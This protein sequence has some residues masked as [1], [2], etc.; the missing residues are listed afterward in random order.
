MDNY[1]SNFAILFPLGAC[2]YIAMRLNDG[3]VD[4]KRGGWGRSIVYS[5]ISLITA[6]A[7]AGIMFRLG[8]ISL[9]WL[10]AFVFAMLVIATRSLSLNR[11]A[12]FRSLSM[13]TSDVARQRMADDFMKENSW[14]VHR[15]ASRF[16]QALH[17]GRPW[18]DAMQESGIAKTSS[19]VFACRSVALY[20]KDLE[21]S[22]SPLLSPMRM[23]QEVERLLGRIY[24]LPWSLIGIAVITLTM[25]IIVPTFKEMFEEFDLTLPPIMEAFIRMSDLVTRDLSPLLYPLFGFVFLAAMYVVLAWLFPKLAQYYPLRPFTQGYYQSLGIT[26]LAI[27]LRHEPDFATA[28]TIASRLMPVSFIAHRL[29]RTAS[30]SQQGYSPD[31]ALQLAPLL[32]YNHAAQLRSSVATRSLPW[33][34]EQVAVFVTERTLRRYSML[35]Q[36]MIVLMVL[37]L[38]FFYG[39]MAIAFIQCLST[40]VLS[41]A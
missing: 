11:D 33:A 21:Q 41:L 36:F 32:S 18:A 9:I 23:Q 17:H 19:Q 39:W 10:V 3:Q 14:F 30:L 1:T 31:K 29:S 8:A 2:L 7:V 37:V 16:R 25:W 34:L 4:G 12:M 24:P 38:G 13:M 15:R 6:F 35:I 40:M 22:I 27:A 5:T 28:C 20:G 26:S